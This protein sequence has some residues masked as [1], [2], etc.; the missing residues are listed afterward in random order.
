MPKKP[1]SI[2]PR[3]ARIAWT[4]VESTGLY[5]D[6]GSTLLQVAIIVTDGLFNELA[7][8]ESKLSVDASEANRLYLSAGDYV[9]AMHEKT[10]LW[11]AIVGEPK[12]HEDWDEEV[13]T[14]LQSVHA[15]PQFMRMGGNSITLDRMHLRAFM[16]KTLEFLSYRNLDMSSI[17][18][19]DELAAKT[20]P[21]K[22]NLAHEALAD[23]RES[24]AQARYH[25]DERTPF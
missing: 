23:I 22:K 4:D 17:E 1:Q 18:Y 2:D 12:S 9:K 6:E 5:P 24:I 21:Y 14:W 10:G 13:L 15:T 8:H 3:E 7:V 20:P 16:P 25:R 19:F 11:D